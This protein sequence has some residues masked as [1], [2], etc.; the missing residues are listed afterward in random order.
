VTAIKRPVYELTTYELNARRSALERAIREIPQGGRVPDDLQNELGEV[1][2]EQE[3]RSRIRQLSRRNDDEDRYCVR[4][5]TTA[6][7]ERV[8]RELQANLGL[9]TDDSPARVPIEAHLQAID[10]EL[11]ERADGHHLPG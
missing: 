9:I 10:A 11:A 4:Q 5:Q 7:L 2:G 3:Q 8:I 1:I 6:E